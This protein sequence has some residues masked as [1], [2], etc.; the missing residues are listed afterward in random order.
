MERPAYKGG[1][2]ENATSVFGRPMSIIR[3]QRCHIMYSSSQCI[4][5]VFKCYFLGILYSHSWNLLLEILLP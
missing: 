3:L 2:E 1:I 5:C 4:F